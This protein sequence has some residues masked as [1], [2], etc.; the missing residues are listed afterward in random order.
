MSQLNI[1]GKLIFDNRIRTTE[2]KTGATYSGK[3]V[4]RKL[5]TATNVAP[6]T[7]SNRQ[8]VTIETT[9]ANMDTLINGYGTVKYNG[10]TYANRVYSLLGA[11][12]DGNMDILVAGAIRVSGT[13]V[14][15]FFC[16]K[17]SYTPTTAN[18]VMVLEYTKT[19]D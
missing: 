10:G 19:T 9:V 3:P 11:Q 1:G 18:M 8:T 13:T 6:A 5:V 14:T 17:P 16:M 4:Y 15:G 2:T 12:V 7:Y